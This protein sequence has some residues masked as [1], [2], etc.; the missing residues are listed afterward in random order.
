MASTV[1]L[2]TD[3]LISKPEV[4]SSCSVPDKGSVYSFR[5]WFAE[6]SGSSRKSKVLI[7]PAY[8]L[9]LEVF[10]AGSKKSRRCSCFEP[11]M[12]SRKVRL[13]ACAWRRI[14]RAGRLT[15]IISNSSGIANTFVASLLLLDMSGA[16]MALRGIA[17]C[18]C[19]LEWLGSLR[20]LCF[21]SGAL[22]LV[23]VVGMSLAFVLRQVDGR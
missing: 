12:V 16:A 22:L 18:S 21:D 10:V 1:L 9:E 8:A 15:S 19:C 5:N 2:L 17:A 20:C 4:R 23:R 7:P 13:V 14:S 6:I 11:L 3:S